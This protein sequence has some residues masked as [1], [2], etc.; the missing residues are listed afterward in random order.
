METNTSQDFFGIINVNKPKGFTSHDVVAKLRKILKIKQIGHT[1]TLDP[2]ATGVL[3]VCIGKATKIIQYLESSKAYRAFI[4]LGIKTDTYDMEGEILETNPVD[5]DLNKIKKHLATFKGE[6]T[7]IPPIYSA[8]HYK[9]KRLYEYA[10]KNIE[11]NDIPT[12]Q[13]IVNSIELIDVLIC[14]C[15]RSEAIHQLLTNEWIASSQAPRN[16]DQFLKNSENPILIVDIDCSEG[17]Y[18]RSIAHDLGEKLGYG[19][20]LSD[21][22]RTKAGK[23]N[24]EKS[25]TLEEI[26]SF[27]KIGDFDKFLINPVEILPL[28][29]FEVEENLLKKIKN[30]QYFPTCHAELVS[31]SQNHETLKQVQGDNSLIQHGNKSILQLVYKNKLAAIARFEDNIIK[32]VNVFI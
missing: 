32:P 6:I 27:Y 26:E 13:V 23:F 22:T 19:A 24:L 21:L 17:T 16:D 2:M 9:G 1:G 11:I 31:V 8:V 30:G 7:Q 20:C 5:L 25:H 12:R 4:K 28:E 18:I 15:E 29:L 14:H 10:R 3:P